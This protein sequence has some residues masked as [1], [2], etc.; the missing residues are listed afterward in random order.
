MESTLENRFHFL[1]QSVGNVSRGA[2]GFPVLAVHE[3]LYNATVMQ[4]SCGGSTTQ[5]AGPLEQQH[6]AA[7]LNQRVWHRVNWS[8]KFI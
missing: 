8:W 7:G 3:W 5:G 6:K 1:R 4:R 2:R